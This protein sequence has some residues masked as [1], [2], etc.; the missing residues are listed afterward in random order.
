MVLKKYFVVGVILV[1]ID[2]RFIILAILT[3]WSERMGRVSKRETHK[4]IIRFE[5]TIGSFV[6]GYL[7]INLFWY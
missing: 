2:F 1:L 7:I 5:W 3:L 4:L 6:S